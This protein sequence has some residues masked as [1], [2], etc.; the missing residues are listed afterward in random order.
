MGLVEATKTVLAKYA[1]FSGRASRSEFWWWTLAYIIIIFIAGVI[2]SAVIVP[3]LGIE[4]AARVGGLP[5]FAI[6]SL[7]LF[8]P[9]IAVAVRRLHDQDRSGWW[10]LIMFVPI[11]G[12][13]F[14]LF[15]YVRRGTDGENRFGPSVI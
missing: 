10:L 6:A 8:I 11:I 13:L 7:A 3:V 12:Y 2:D 5:L 14:L 4:A 15:F 9:S 1:N